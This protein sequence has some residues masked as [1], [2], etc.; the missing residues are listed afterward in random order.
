MQCCTMTWQCTVTQCSAVQYLNYPDITLVG[1][2]VMHLDGC[3]CSG[4]AAAQ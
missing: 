3:H 2:S 1:V 4:S